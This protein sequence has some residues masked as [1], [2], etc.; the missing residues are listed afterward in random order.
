M[1]GQILH[2]TTII[3][4]T[5][6]ILLVIGAV[7]YGISKEHKEN[8]EV[9]DLNTRLY[10][11]KQELHQ[12][13][14]TGM[15]HFGKRITVADAIALKMAGEEVDLKPVINVFWPGADSCKKCDDGQCWYFIENQDMK[16]S[17]LLEYNSWVRP[18]LFSKILGFDGKIINV[19]KTT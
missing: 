11:G 10:R 4:L 15:T 16:C 7:Q 5:L 6:M 18:Y 8:T 13:L 19:G 12:F 9:L 3:L 14:N 2:W 17:E 1:K